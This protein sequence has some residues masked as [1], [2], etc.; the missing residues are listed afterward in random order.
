MSLTEKA[1]A[2]S[3]QASSSCSSAQPTTSGNPNDGLEGG[4]K[5]GPARALVA[6]QLR[7]AQMIIF[8]G[9]SRWAASPHKVF[10]P[11]NPALGR[12]EEAL[13]LK[14]TNA[15]GWP[16]STSSARLGMSKLCQDVG[17]R[18]AMQ[19]KCRSAAVNSVMGGILFFTYD[20]LRPKGHHGCTLGVSTAAFVAGG[21]H[22]IL[23][24]PLEEVSSRLWRDP[25]AT[26]RGII[27]TEPNGLT[28]WFPARVVLLSGARDAIGMTA[29]FS[30]FEEVRFQLR[31]F[32]F[33]EVVPD[34]L[35]DYVTPG[36]CDQGI[37]SLIAGAASGASYRLVAHPLDTFHM[38]RLRKMSACSSEDAHQFRSGM[39]SQWRRCLSD[40][41]WQGFVPSGRSLLAAMPASAVG[42]LLY[43]FMK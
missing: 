27:T 30:A 7:A 33:N 17:W 42:L 15:E 26:F 29:F 37:T 19:I 39:V 35:H 36:R 18:R 6:Q 22:G 12:F 4:W 11:E 20:T 38:W 13:S 2:D 10:R 21:L 16:R 25:H 3:N 31:H 1:T 28:V 14:G 40:V 41:G 24:A 23:C 32:Q 5:A 8:R 9:I 34:R 43:D